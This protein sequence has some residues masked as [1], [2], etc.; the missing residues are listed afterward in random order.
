MKSYHTE[1][2]KW[3]GLVFQNIA[4]FSIW[5]VCYLTDYGKNSSKV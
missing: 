4:W 3:V 2:M 1:G 5:F